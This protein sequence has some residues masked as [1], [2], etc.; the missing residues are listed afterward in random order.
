MNQKQLKELI[1]KQHD[2]IDFLKTNFDICKK[3]SY[4]VEAESIKTQIDSVNSFI[5][6]LTEYLK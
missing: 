2:K 6:E 5:M 3:L 4:T 1:T